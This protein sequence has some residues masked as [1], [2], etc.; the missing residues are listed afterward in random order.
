MRL[1]ESEL[2]NKV[3]SRFDDHYVAADQQRG[4]FENT[5]F[6]CRSKGAPP[7]VWHEPDLKNP[8]TRNFQLGSVSLI[9]EIA[10]RMMHNQKVLQRY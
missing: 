8:K 5:F 7:A 9:R 3:Q 4:N 10:E 1:G 2:K 6:L